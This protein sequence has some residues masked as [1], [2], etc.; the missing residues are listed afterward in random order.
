MPTRVIARKPLVRI[1]I[2]HKGELTSL[3]YHIANSSKQ[4]QVALYK[5]ARRYGIHSVIRKITAL[6]TFNR[7]GPQDKLRR[8]NSDLTYLHKLL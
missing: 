4:R 5:A 7:N 6:K 3:G 1:Q 8:L 2:K